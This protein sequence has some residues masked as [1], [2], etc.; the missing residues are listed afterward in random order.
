MIALHG[1][2]E[3]QFQRNAQVETSALSTESGQS[4]GSLEQGMYDLTMEATGSQPIISATET[5]DALSLLTF[6]DD[7]FRG[8]MASTSELDV[9]ALATRLGL[10]KPKGNYDFLS[11]RSNAC[12]CRSAKYQFPSSPCYSW[13]GSLTLNA[14]VTPNIGRTY[15][16]GDLNVTGGISE[17]LL[18]G[19]RCWQCQSKRRR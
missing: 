1:A 15:I 18:S 19:N 5:H 3:E 11:L 13:G 17:R 2:L 16:N 9:T 4:N 12:T 6:P 14:A 8:A 7:P 10:T